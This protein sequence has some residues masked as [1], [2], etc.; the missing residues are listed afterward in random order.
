MIFLS[1]QGVSCTLAV[2]SQAYA[3]LNPPFMDIN[4]MRE[5]PSLAAARHASRFANNIEPVSFHPEFCSRIPNHSISEFLV[6]K[7][8]YGNSVKCLHQICF[9]DILSL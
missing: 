9:Y 8:R 4:P 6:K 5:A 2:S 3:G 7:W 1:L